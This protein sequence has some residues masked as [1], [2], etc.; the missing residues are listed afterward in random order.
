VPKNLAKAF[1]SQ[2][3]VVLPGG[4]NHAFPLKTA[5]TATLASF[6]SNIEE[7]T[8][9][10]AAGGVLIPGKSP[11]GTMSI[12]TTNEDCE[13]SKSWG[14]IVIQYKLE[15]GLQKA[16]HPNPG[17]S[18]S[19][20]STLAYLPNTPAGQA[21]LKRLK[22]AFRHGSTFT[23]GTDHSTRAPNVSVWQIQHKTAQCGGMSQNG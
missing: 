18:Y 4:T 23:V 6:R 11:S 21:L 15:G 3:K 16:Y 9:Y 19:S 5:A 7:C 13:N 14:S 22:Y 1:A 10:N 20:T 17:T 8:A 2:P 12:T